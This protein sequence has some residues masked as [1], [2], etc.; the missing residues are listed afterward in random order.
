MGI[1]ILAGRVMEWNEGNEAE[2]VVVVNRALADHYWPDR[3]ALGRRIRQNAENSEWSAV[4]VG[5]VENVRQWGAEHRPLP[6]MYQPYRHFPEPDSKLIIRGSGRVLSMVPAIRQQVLDLDSN[7]PISDVRTME[8]VLGGAT[9]GRQFLLLLV[10]LFAVI[11][12]LLAAAGV[13][14]IMSHNVAQRTREMGIRVA[15]GAIPGDLVSM[16][17]R[18]AVR[19]AVFGLALGAILFAL[20]GSVIRNQLYGV[21]S[22]ATMPMA[23]AGLML[24]FVALAASIIPAMRVTRFDP[25]RVLRSD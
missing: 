19:L 8:Q 3:D 11:A 15:F 22:I 1:P 14:G 7:Q 21:N 23:A 4:V 17:L 24:L 5:V 13:F 12:V 9:R 6:E 16:V 10:S 2:R 25:N 18:Q 20:S